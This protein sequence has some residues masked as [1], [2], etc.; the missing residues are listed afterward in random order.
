MLEIETPGTI[1]RPSRGC[2]ENTSGCNEFGCPNTCFCEDHCRWDRCALYEGPEDCLRGTNSS[3][4]RNINHF[5]AKPKG[6]YLGQHR[7]I[8]ECYNRITKSGY[9][10]VYIV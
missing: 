10:N 2:P 7:S 6:M 1:S 8:I 9:H 5:L 3:W 4:Q